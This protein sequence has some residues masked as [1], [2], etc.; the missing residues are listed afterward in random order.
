[1]Q[2]RL[3]FVERVGLAAVVA[4]KLITDRTLTATELDPD[5]Y[6]YTPPHRPDLN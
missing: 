2:R 1:M 3:T 6:H 4:W 5:T